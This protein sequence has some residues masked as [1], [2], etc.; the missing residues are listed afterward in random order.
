MTTTPTIS[1]IFDDLSVLITGATGSFGTAMCEY[2]LKQTQVRRVIVLSRD[3][4]K[5]WQM[6][7]K[8]LFHD[9]RLRFFLGDVRDKDRLTRAFRR[10]DI[11]I[12]AAAL[13]QVPAAEY[14]PS[15]FIKTNVLGTLNVTEAALEASVPRVL[16]LSTDKAVSPINLYG[17]TKLC[18]EK[19]ILAAG[20]YSDVQHSTKFSVLR[21][22]N[23][24]MSRGSVIELWKKMIQEGA[25]DLPITDI[26][27]TRF[28][29]TLDQ[30]TRYVHTALED[31]QGGEIFIPRIR[32]MRLTELASVMA[33]KLKIRL[34]GKRPGEK[35]H[36]TLLNAHESAL[37]YEQENR[38]IVLP[39]LEGPDY[40][41]K[42]REWWAARA[43]RLPRDYSFASNENCEF[44]NRSE[45]EDLL[46]QLSN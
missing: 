36:E 8:P 43:K 41:K 4:C 20:V 5:Q 18:A 29:I 31:M 21:Y 44:L 10:V 25:T 40:L 42:T 16:F 15:E 9:P 26:D 17:A 27:M 6:Q 14:N 19:L 3:E 35:L 28:W 11:V 38:F 23:V 30:A 37:A 13:K 34:V 33:P 7:Q 46:K 22:G 24:M 1:T 12:H 2:L 45:M 39:E 32:S